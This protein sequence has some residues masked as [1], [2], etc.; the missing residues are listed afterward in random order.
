MRR[1]LIGLGALLLTSSCSSGTQSGSPPSSAA[2]APKRSAAD[3]GVPIADAYT[4]LVAS[5]LGPRATFSFRGTDGKYHVVY[6]LAL[7]NAS[8]IPATLQ[9]IAVVDA[10]RPSRV[11]ASFEG[12]P[13][14]ERLRTLMG[15]GGI[16]TDATIEPSAGR[17]LYVDLVFDSLERAPRAVQH[18]VNARGASNPGARE[19]TPLD[20]VITPYEISAGAPMV[21]G[22]PLMGPGWVALNGCCE[23]GW[24]HRSSDAPVSGRIANGQR[25][26][27]DWKRMNEQ[28][29]FYVGDRTR[30]ESYVDYG[31]DVLAVAD[32]VVT[33][34]LDAFDPNV[35]GILPARDPVLGPRIT[36]Q[37]V[38]GNHIV[39]DLGNGLYAFYAHLLKGSLMVKTGD[40]VRRGDR[41]AK[42]GNT[43]NS[44][45]PHLHFH[46]MDGPSPLASYGVPYVI[47][48][49]EYA[50][51]VSLQQILDADDYLTGT[52][53][54]QRL[55]VPQPRRDELPLAW[56]IVNFPR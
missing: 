54:G 25:F 15:E 8:R 14:L 19:A 56:A 1:M 3:L 29:A 34:T 9:S 30:N 2:T 26:A 45:A 7:L 37:T 36:V 33:M 24:P 31:S 5:V 44:N 46:V 17:I 28:G 18:R 23:P 12:R 43:G 42:L 16:V 39:V 27:I 47:S 11:I 41:I 52:F 22:P 51:Q 53:G 55:A 38:D 35:P 6:D 32:G 21:L 48:G 10:A 50:G 40:P 4:P 13:L 20:Y 49:F